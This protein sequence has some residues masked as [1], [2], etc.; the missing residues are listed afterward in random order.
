[1]S[2][3]PEKTI[4]RCRVTTQLEFFVNATKSYEY[5]EPGTELEI[6]LANESERKDMADRDKAGRPDQIVV[7]WQNRRRMLPR[8]AVQVLPAKVRVA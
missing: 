2:A 3:S 5:L 7:M 4:G 8:A 1:V 6:L